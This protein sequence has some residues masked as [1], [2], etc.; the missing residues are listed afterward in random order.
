MGRREC[1]FVTERSPGDC[2]G[3]T[4]VG[5]RVTRCVRDR[6]YPERYRGRRMDGRRQYV[7]SWWLVRDNHTWGECVR[8][9]WSEGLWYLGEC[10][11][12]RERTRAESVRWVYMYSASETCVCVNQG[13]IRPVWLA[14]WASFAW[15]GFPCTLISLAELQTLQV[16]WPR[17]P[18][19]N[20]W[21]CGHEAN[22]NMDGY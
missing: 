8:L 4:W 13:D 1:M 22:N 2:D 18:I 3:T 7:C 14:S 11:S 17:R 19:S 21:S 15:P 12:H 5:D 16:A 9:W 10:L 6:R 20:A